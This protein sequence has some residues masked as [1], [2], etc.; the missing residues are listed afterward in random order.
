MAR[1]SEATRA[2]IFDAATAEF[3]AYGIAGARIDRIARAAKANKQ[4]IYAYFGDKEQ[5]FIV[6]LERAVKQIAEAIPIDVEDIPGYATRLRDYHEKHPELL[7]L[8]LWEALERGRHDL[9]A[10]TENAAER[11]AHYQD[12]V[13]S[14]AAA[15]AAGRITSELP[16]GV[17]MMFI[18]SLAGWPSAVPQVRQMLVGDADYVEALHLAATRLTAP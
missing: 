15:Q 5:L 7:R 14:V 13:E 1:D 11:T 16:A 4:L 12:K 2:R 9:P 10:G 17:I 6:V 3:A 8:L 18:L